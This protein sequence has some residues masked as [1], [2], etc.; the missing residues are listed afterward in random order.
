MS[1]HQANHFELEEVIIR[2]LCGADLDLITDLDPRAQSDVAVDHCFTRLTAAEAPAF[3]DRRHAGLSRFH[4]QHGDFQ[5]L[6][7]GND[8]GG[9]SVDR[10]GIRHPI[11]AANRARGICLQAAGRND[12]VRFF[13]K[14]DQLRVQVCQVLAVA[15]GK[16]FPEGSDEQHKQGDQGDHQA[17]EKEATAI[18]E[19]FLECQVEGK[20]EIFHYGATGPLKV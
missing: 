15:I 13:Q 7:E 8:L 14:D 20:K 4:T 3:D 17:E 1:I 19:D 2:S 10:T 5:R 6:R 12:E 9:G 11:H 16:S 18:A